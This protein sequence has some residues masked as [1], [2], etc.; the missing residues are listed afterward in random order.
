MTPIPR[1]ADRTLKEP[2]LGLKDA[3]GRDRQKRI[4]ATELRQGPA[5]NHPRHPGLA[6]RVLRAVELEC[7]VPDAARG[8]KPVVRD[9]A[10]GGVGRMA[11]QS[12]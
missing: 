2:E 11:T 8:F 9:G 1:S 5:T 7:P 4:G 6:S 3:D 10:L 12:C